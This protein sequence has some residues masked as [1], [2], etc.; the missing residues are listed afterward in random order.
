M[1]T[2]KYEK[3][4]IKSLDES[5]ETEAL[6]EPVELT[7]ESFAAFISAQRNALLVLQ[8][9]D[10]YLDECIATFEKN[11]RNDREE[12]EGAYCY[13]IGLLL[14]VARRFHPFSPYG[15]KFLKDAVT[16]RQEFEE[17]VGPLITPITGNNIDLFAT[18]LNEDL[19]EDILSGRRNA[20][21]A[22]R[23][24]RGTIYGVGI[25][26]WHMEPEFME[27]K[28]LIIDWLFVNSRFRQRQ[29]AHQLMGEFLFR[30]AATG[31]T[32]VTAEFSDQIP[33]KQ[34]MAYIM[35]AWQFELAAGIDRDAVI[36]VGNV[37]GY[38]VIEKNKK[39]ACSLSSLDNKKGNALVYSA[40]RDFG[41]EGFLFRVSDD[42]IDREHS[43]YMKKGDSVISMI[44]MHK[45]PS[46]MLRTEYLG[47]MPGQEESIHTVLSAMLESAVLTGPDD[48]LVMVPVDAE[49]T[50]EYLAE[51]CPKQFGMYLVAGT[52]EKPAEYMNATYEEM[53]ALFEEE[54]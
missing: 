6:K 12:A 19:R 27:G 54:E 39:G 20:I 51:I 37:T 36:K 46:G 38:T 40:L 18:V 14:S 17:L 42:Y 9:I 34:T 2:N 21:G 26:A 33:E 16:C 31:G 3:A 11:K 24:R 1:K 15:L 7:P 30:V 29:V 47:A 35:N 50:G 48:M 43:Y 45:T 10:L 13:K 44:V 4:K 5:L 23:T 28:Q 52:L 53:E 49:E 32:H 41:Y 25:L 8:K 22:L